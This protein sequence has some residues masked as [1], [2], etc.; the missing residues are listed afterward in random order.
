MISKQRNTRINR[1][2]KTPPK[3]LLEREGITTR[4]WKAMKRKELREVIKAFDYYR[5]GCAYCPGING[6]VITI[7]KSLDKLKQSLSVKEWGR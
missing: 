3:W 5:L 1:E 2:P 7:G 6:E 4:Q